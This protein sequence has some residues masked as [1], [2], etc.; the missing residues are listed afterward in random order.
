MNCKLRLS[1][2]WLST[3][4]C[5]IRGEF[6]KRAVSTTLAQSNTFPLADGQESDPDDL[7][8]A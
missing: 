5:I 4:K 3:L 7:L 8:F 2:L 1:I 6:L